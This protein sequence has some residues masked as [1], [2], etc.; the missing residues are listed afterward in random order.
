MTAT[1]RRQLSG[2]IYSRFDRVSQFVTP[3]SQPLA[4]H[5]LY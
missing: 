2:Q 4:L 5:I 1:R 3:V